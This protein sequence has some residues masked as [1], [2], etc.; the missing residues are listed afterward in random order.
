MRLKSQARTYQGDDDPGV[1]SVKRIFKYYKQYGY[2][3][4]LMDAS[5]RNVGVDS[6]SPFPLSISNRSAVYLL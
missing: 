6:Q 5:F 2:N 3:T 1:Q 4:I